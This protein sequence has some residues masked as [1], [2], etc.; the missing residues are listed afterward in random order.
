MPLEQNRH[1][2]LQSLFK[3]VAHTRTLDQRPAEIKPK[4]L[5]ESIFVN[6]NFLE[7]TLKLSHLWNKHSMIE[8]SRF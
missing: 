3:K 1:N 7:F 2:Y 4:K 6:Y 8:L 5:N